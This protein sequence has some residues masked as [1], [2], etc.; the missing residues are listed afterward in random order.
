MESPNPQQTSPRITKKDNS[1]GNTPKKDK[2]MFM[3]RSRQ[4]TSLLDQLPE[5]GEPAAC[6]SV[7]MSDQLD[8]TLDLQSAD[9]E[10]D[11]RPGVDIE[12][13]NISDQEIEFASRH[14]Q[15]QT[16]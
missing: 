14:H 11:K 5:Q 2:K 16:V 7:P 15:R 13:S 8:C 1:P 9:C 3:T 6:E 4:T 10:E 12:C